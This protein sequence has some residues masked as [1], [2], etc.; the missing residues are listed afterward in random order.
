M[1]QTLPDYIKEHE[2]FQQALLKMD[3]GIMRYLAEHLDT[4]GTAELFTSYQNQCVEEFFEK[5]KWD[6]R[7]VWEGDDMRRAALGEVEHFWKELRYQRELKAQ[8]AGMPA[9]I[10]EIVEE[11]NE[12]Y[13]KYAYRQDRKRR[14]PAGMTPIDFYQEVIDLYHSSGLADKCMKIVLREHHAKEKLEKSNSDLFTEFIIRQ[15]VDN[16][17]NGDF[18]LLRQAVAEM[19]HGKDQDQCRQMAIDTMERVMSFSQMIYTESI[20][21]AFREINFNGEADKRERDGEWLRD[22]A[23]RA[24]L[25]EFSEHI[26]TH[27]MGYYFAIFVNLLI[28]LGRIWA[29]QLLVHGIDMKELESRVPCIMNPMNTPRYYVDKYYSDDLPHKYCVSNDR[30][31]EELLKKIG[32]EFSQKCY[33]KLADD[34]SNEKEV[35]AKLCKAYKVLTTEG[36]IDARKTKMETFTNVMMNNLDA[37]IYWQNDPR[38]KFLKEFILVVI[39]LSKS[40]EYSPLL[41]PSDKG[42]QW[43][44]VKQHFVDDKGDDIEI[45]SNSTKLGKKDKD[46]FERILKAVYVFVNP[47]QKRKRS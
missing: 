43:A 5:N 40:Y 7:V 12:Q 39:G 28:D 10:V 17:I 16:L 46:Q 15:Y 34:D 4:N 18:A 3:G 38:S 11:F 33:L 6:L 47:Y 2:D 13:L 14:H 20:V 26:K 1:K 35:L 23:H 41:I 27:S 9:D 45:R 32:R 31:A 30:R 22:V 37:K 29:A 24:V 25:E 19:L 44:F 21:R 8:L 36:F 42:K